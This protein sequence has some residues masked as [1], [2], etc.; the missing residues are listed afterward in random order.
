MSDK[1]YKPLI[2]ELLNSA[3]EKQLE[4]LYFF[5]LTFLS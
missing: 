3:T 4:R 5:I 2:I 1:N